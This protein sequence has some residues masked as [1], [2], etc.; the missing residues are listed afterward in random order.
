ME[1]APYHGVE[2]EEIDLQMSNMCAG[3]VWTVEGSLFALAYFF[4]SLSVRKRRWFGRSKVI[5]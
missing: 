5:S 1:Y 2:S 3:T 4:C